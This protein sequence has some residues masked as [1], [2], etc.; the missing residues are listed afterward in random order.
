MYVSGV[1]V[2]TCLVCSVCG[3]A[4]GGWEGESGCFESVWG[5]LRGRVEGRGGGAK[6]PKVNGLGPADSPRSFRRRHR[7]GSRPAL[8]AS[9]LSGRFR[10]RSNATGCWAGYATAPSWRLRWRLL[11]PCRETQAPISA[12]GLP[13]SRTV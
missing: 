11:R 4:C 5:V 12:G 2:V 1:C 10:Q 8:S 3:D 7:E 9:E 6:R 13:V